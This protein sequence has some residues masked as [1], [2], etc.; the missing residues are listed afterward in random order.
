MSNDN[1][2]QTHRD[3]SHRH[4]PVPTPTSHVMRFADLKP[5]HTVIKRRRLAMGASLRELG[6]T[7]GIGFSKLGAIESRTRTCPMA[8]GFT[9]AEYFGTTIEML[10]DGRGFALKIGDEWEVERR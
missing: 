1:E 3:T 2:P 5:W 4:L 7:V 10:F 9:L 6:E 8:D